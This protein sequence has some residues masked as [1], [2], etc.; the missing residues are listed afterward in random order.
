MHRRVI[1]A[2]ATVIVAAQLSFTRSAAAADWPQWRGPDR[3]N[4]SREAGLLQ[5]WPTNGPPLLWTVTGLGEGITA[6]AL[7]DGRAYTLGYHDD[8]EFVLALDAISGETRWTARIGPA[9]NPKAQFANS[10]MRWLSPRVPT[11]DRDRIYT[12]TAAGDLTCLRTENGTVLWR[13]SYPRDFLS[14][15]RT[16]G[17]CDY[18]LVDGGNLICLPGASNAAVVALNKRTGDLVWKTAVPAD[19]RNAHAATVISTAGGIRHY[20]VFLHDGLAGI[21]AGDGRL[22]WRYGRTATRLA[23]SYTPVVRDDLVFT[24]NGYGGGMALLKLVREGDGLVAVEQYHRKFTFSPFQDN[25]VLVG[26]HVYAVQGAGQ[27]VCFDLHTGELAWG[28]VGSERQRRSAMIYA[29]S[30]LYVR[31]SDGSMT[32]VEA[33]PKAYLEKGTF[34]IPHPEEVLGVTFP[35][36][37]G[38]RLYLRDNNR[39]LCYD[40]RADA[41]SHPRTEPNTLAVVITPT[42]APPTVTPSASLP[43]EGQRAPDAIF[44]PTPADVVEK[45]LESAA[46]TAGSVLYDLGSGDGRI[47]MAAARKHGCRAVGYELDSHLVE[48]SRETARSNGLERLVR[49]ERADLFTADLSDADVVVVYLPTNLLA[50]LRPQFDR[51]KPGA[52]V[53]SHQFPIPG[54]RPATSLDLVST[55]DGDR[56]RV[57]LWKA[58]LDSSKPSASPQGPHP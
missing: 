34:R 33:T 53:V 31:R 4:A 50:R 49:I 2:L 36:V 25:T 43:A 44:V 37:A 10:L 23:N 24:A 17:F 28:P 35:V 26:D 56:H 45:M 22:L 21:A 32:L 13:K 7:A 27:A 5:R 48:L 38:G 52:R 16:W 57:F 1:L 39:L 58:P 55:E 41:L 42:P 12:I 18:P 51:L 15:P 47:V 54:L 3:S 19:E 46:L 14:K 11:V 29:D 40:V 6:L 8:G 9:A 30:H 20:V